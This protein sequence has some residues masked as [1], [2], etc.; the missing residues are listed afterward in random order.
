MLYRSLNILE[1]PFAADARF[2]ERRPHFAKAGKALKEVVVGPETAVRWRW[3]VQDRLVV[4]GAVVAARGV[5][6]GTGAIQ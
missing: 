1:P 5:R 3:T 4:N 6:I 2:A